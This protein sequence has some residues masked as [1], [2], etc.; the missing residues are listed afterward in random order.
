MKI[1]ELKLKHFSLL[2]VLYVLNTYCYSQV[3]SIWDHKGNL[4]SIKNIKSFNFDS[5]SNKIIISNCCD[6]T[7]A[8]IVSDSLSLTRLGK[9]FNFYEIY[10]LLRYEDYND[11][12]KTEKIK[13]FSKKI[14]KG[15]IY[16]IS[17]SN[18]LKNEI[19]IDSFQLD[20]FSEFEKNGN[21]IIYK[22]YQNGLLHGN[23]IENNS[24]NYIYTSFYRGERLSRTMINNSKLLR[25]NS[26]KNSIHWNNSNNK[27]KTITSLNQKK[28]FNGTTLSFYE[29]GSIFLK[30][31][32]NNNIR[33]G[34]WVFFKE[35][36]V[37]EKE[38]DY[39]TDPIWREH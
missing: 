14:K 17:D 19:F 8:I 38:E 15:F 11:S 36:G 26:A 39:P 22:E 5:T 6:N 13:A 24:G 12:S 33:I 34:K 25:K 35:N 1:K 18:W 20:F 16:L 3:Q 27:I 28:E 31:M 23:F 2:I 4:L 21:L 7:I 30:G 37:I 29:N 10:D 9:K 32:Y